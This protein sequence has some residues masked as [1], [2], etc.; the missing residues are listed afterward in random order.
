[1]ARVKITIETNGLETAIEDYMGSPGTTGDENTIDMVA[2]VVRRSVAALVG[3]DRYGETIATI[4]GLLG[5]TENTPRTSPLL[6]SVA[7]ARE[8][9]TTH[10]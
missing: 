7:I 9:A 8:Q 5:R 3:P 1:M 4:I 2:S 6:A 10:E